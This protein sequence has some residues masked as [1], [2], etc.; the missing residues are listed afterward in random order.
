MSEY[1]D[2]LRELN[3]DSSPLS[4]RAAYV[5]SELLRG[6]QNDMAEIT[7]LRR[8]IERMVVDNNG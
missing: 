1:A 2:L 8:L 7:R 4:K 3:A 6:R 5:I